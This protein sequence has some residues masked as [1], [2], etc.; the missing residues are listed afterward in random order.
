MRSGFS[1]M[2]MPAPPKAV[3]HRSL[4]TLREKP[5]ET[6]SKI[7]SH[8]RYVAVHQAEIAMPRKLIRTIFSLIDGPRPAILPP[9][10]SIRITRQDG[11]VRCRSKCALTMRDGRRAGLL[12]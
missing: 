3:E 6:G 9:S 7:V 8:G 2:R 1:F 5:I 10:G 11:Y 4:T 12:N